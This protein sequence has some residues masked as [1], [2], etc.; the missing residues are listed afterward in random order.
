MDG[1]IKRHKNTCV[2][3]VC[4]HSLTQVHTHAHTHAHTHTSLSLSLSL[5]APQRWRR[6]RQRVWDAIID[7]QIWNTSIKV[8]EGERCVVPTAFPLVVLREAN[9]CVG[10]RVCV[11]V[12]SLVVVVLVGCQD[13]SFAPQLSRVL[14]AIAPVLPSSLPPPFD[15]HRPARCRCGNLLP[16]PP[17]QFHHQHSSRPLLLCVCCR[18]GLAHEPV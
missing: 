18:S 8:L 4:A 14:R 12:C 10:V 15:T 1:P 6:F 3:A 5:C 11:N 7:S 13:S 16:L 2:V 17:A 9:V